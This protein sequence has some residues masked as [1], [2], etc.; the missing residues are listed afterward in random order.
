[1]MPNLNPAGFVAV[2]ITVMSAILDIL[3]LHLSVKVRPITRD[4]KYIQVIAIIELI[5]PFVGVTDVIIT[6][7]HDNDAILTPNLCQYL[8]FFSVLVL[9]LQIIFNALLAIERYSN[10]M[11]F[12]Y[13]NYLILIVIM[14]SLLYIGL[15]SYL[16]FSMEFIPNASGII[17]FI[18]PF[19]STVS[20]ITFYYFMTITLISAITIIYCYSKLAIYTYKLDK[21][22]PI[23]AFYRII[24]L[25]LLYA[26]CMFSAMVFYLTESSL[27]LFTPFND[28][29]IIGVSSA[30][31]L[32]AT[33]GILL[34]SLLVLTMHT[35]INKELR[36]LFRK[37]RHRLPF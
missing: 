1:M 19:K 23:G 31:T 18:F 3:L 37:I 35:A 22:I 7:M 25:I 24:L 11:K 17:C 26:M 14:L 10:I 13:N 8:G 20:T 15:S 27:S 33:T 34:N 16:A 9:F 32:L 29:T 5:A 4:I 21:F 30:A 2:G 36:L 6:T 12:H 28:S